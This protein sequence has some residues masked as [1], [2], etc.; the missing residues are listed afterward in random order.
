[1]DTNQFLV[2]WKDAATAKRVQDEKQEGVEAQVDAT[3]TF[4]INGRRF[5]EPP[6]ALAD[7]IREALDE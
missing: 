1:M 6:S 3:P 2:D 5:R 7:Y 4:F